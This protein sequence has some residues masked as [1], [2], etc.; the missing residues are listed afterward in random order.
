MVPGN[1][2][3]IELKFVSSKRFQPSLIFY[4]SKEDCSGVQ[5]VS[6]RSLISCTANQPANKVQLELS[7]PNFFFSLPHRT[8]WPLVQ[9]TVVLSPEQIQSLNFVPQKGFCEIRACA[10]DAD[11]NKLGDFSDPVTVTKEI[12]ITAAK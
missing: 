5:H 7:S 11:G 10:L 12:E 8:S 9:A 3:K 6:N 1:W 4:N 2:K